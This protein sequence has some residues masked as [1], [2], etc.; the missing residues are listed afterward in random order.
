MSLALGIIIPHH[1]GI[2]T[3]HMNIFDVLSQLGHHF[4]LQLLMHLIK[5]HSIGIVIKISK[6]VNFSE[7][8]INMFAAACNL[9]RMQNILYF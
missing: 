9:T 2:W 6:M 5:V 7:T 1:G 8:I 4:C 3:N